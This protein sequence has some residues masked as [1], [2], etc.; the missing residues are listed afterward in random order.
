MVLIYNYGRFG[1]KTCNPPNWY[2]YLHICYNFYTA[3]LVVS[4]SVWVLVAL[5]LGMSCWHYAKKIDEL[6]MLIYVF[7]D[8]ALKKLYKIA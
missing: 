2:D 3:K 6:R 5:S 4:L 8:I 7:R 1:I